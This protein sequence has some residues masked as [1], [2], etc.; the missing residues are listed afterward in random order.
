MAKGVKR[1]CHSIISGKTFKNE[2][3]GRLMVG[4]ATRSTREVK[5]AGST[6]REACIVE[7][8]KR[9]EERRKNSDSRNVYLIDGGIRTKK[10]SQW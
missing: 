9:R 2:L 3:K 7:Q 4:V 6:K 5:G 8:K 1:E 10:E